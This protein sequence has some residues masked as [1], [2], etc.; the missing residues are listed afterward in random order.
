MEGI[1][2]KFK[3]GKH[4]TGFVISYWRGGY[5]CAAFTT[6]TK[7]F[8]QADAEIRGLRKDQLAFIDVTGTNPHLEHL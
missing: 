3:S 8:I 2:I 7:P 1:Y 6:C 5:R 4:Y